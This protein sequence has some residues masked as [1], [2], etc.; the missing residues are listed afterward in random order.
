[1]EENVA[2]EENIGEIQNSFVT[3]NSKCGKLVVF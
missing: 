1:M 2:T 3:E